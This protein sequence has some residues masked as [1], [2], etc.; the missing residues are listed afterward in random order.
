MAKRFINPN[1]KLLRN[2]NSDLQAAYFYVWDKADCTGVY[3]HDR[4]YFEVDL[5]PKS[6]ITVD[7]L[8]TLPEFKKLDGNRILIKDFLFVNNEGVLKIDYNPHKPIFRAIEK[9]GLEIFADLSLFIEYGK[10][11]EKQRVGFKAWFKL[12][13]ENFK[14]IEEGKGEDEGKDEN[15]KRVQGENH[16]PVEMPMGFL[17]DHKFREINPKYP[18]RPSK[19]I[20]AIIEWANFINSQSGSDNTI[21]FF[22]AIE[23]TTVMDFWEKFAEWYRDTGET[24]DLDY[25]Q[26]FKLQK[27]YT[28]IKNGTAKKPFNSSYS[29][30]GNNPSAVVIR[31][32]KA[33]NTAL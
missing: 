32:D 27:I 19:D 3:V 15:G 29:N 16:E 2:Y 12:E 26:K 23:R 33:F 1:W 7:I 5:K 4:D 31:P 22:T 14:L 6:I 21:S 13:N 28:E 20:P 8:T 17:M 10:K 30:G 11:E 18:Q 25:L 24:N 9:T